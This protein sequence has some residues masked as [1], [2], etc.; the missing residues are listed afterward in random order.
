MLCVY[1]YFNVK[2]PNAGI[3]SAIDSSIYDT[4]NRGSIFLTDSGKL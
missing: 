3:A 2:Q 1:S 4:I